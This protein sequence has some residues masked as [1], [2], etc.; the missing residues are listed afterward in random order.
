M[1]FV[2]FDFNLTIDSK[3]NLGQ[4]NVQVTDAD[5]G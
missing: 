1:I 2:Y 5:K 3:V 4:Q